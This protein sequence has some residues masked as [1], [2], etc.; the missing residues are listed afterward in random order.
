[1]SIILQFLLLMEE[2]NL[3]HYKFLEPV[4]SFL[5]KLNQNNIFLQQEQ[6][7][8]YHFWLEIFLYSDYTSTKLKIIQ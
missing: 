6:K 5:Y 7:T 1:M 3:L 8:E 2:F 4:N